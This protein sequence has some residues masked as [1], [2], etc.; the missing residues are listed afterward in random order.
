VKEKTVSC[1]TGF[2]FGD[3]LDFGDL[4]RAHLR[5]LIKL[6]YIDLK[7]STLGVRLGYSALNPGIDD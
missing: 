1:S 5:R 3:L 7:S 2:N 4:I 6:L